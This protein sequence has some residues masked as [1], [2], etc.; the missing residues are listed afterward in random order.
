MKEMFI[1]KTTELMYKNWVVL[2]CTQC[3]YHHYVYNKLTVDKGYCTGCGREGEMTII[4][5]DEWDATDYLEL[6]KNNKYGILVDNLFDKYKAI[7]KRENLSDKLFAEIIRVASDE[8][9]L[10]MESEEDNY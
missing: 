1:T 9:F 10:L 8:T 6:A 2:S 5:R 3:D 4:P 7:F